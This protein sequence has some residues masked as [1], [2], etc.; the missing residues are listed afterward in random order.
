MLTPDK[1]IVIISKP[2]F[3]EE[4]FIR[5]GRIG[6]DNVSGYLKGGMESLISRP[7][8]I[9]KS[10]RITPLTL[11]DDLIDN[12]QISVLDVRT[13]KEW[14]EGHIKNS[15]NIPLGQLDER[16]DEI[17]SDKETIV[18]CQSGYRS[19]IAASILEK[20]N[21]E[22]ISVLVGGMSG[23]NASKLEVVT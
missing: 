18:T 1:P 11:A 10:E 2:E 21:I 9:K 22:N 19:S 8:L 13:E 6:Y 4:A 23:W 3:T 17:D 15:K 16:L 14:K 5:L 7:E 20:Q 12:N